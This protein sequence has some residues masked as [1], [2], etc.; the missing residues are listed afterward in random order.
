MQPQQPQTPP[1]PSQPQ[2][3]PMPQQ[4]SD[5]HGMLVAGAILSSFPILGLILTIIANN[6]TKERGKNRELALIFLISSIIAHVALVIYVG[7]FVLILGA[8]GEV[9]DST[10]FE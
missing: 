1:P 2:V 3:A 6:Q 8:A 4:R 10:L 5:V 9:T 7:L